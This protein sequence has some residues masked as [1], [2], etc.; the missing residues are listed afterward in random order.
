MAQ[1]R[2]VTMVDDIDGRKADETVSFGLD[3]VLYEID[4]NSKK[5]AALR[6][7]LAE[8]VSAGR[9]IKPPS[10]FRTAVQTRPGRGLAAAGTTAAEVREWAETAGITVSHRGRVSAAL[11]E[12]FLA[13]QDK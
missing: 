11:R 1:Q 5:A 6:K 10:P 4:L 9:Q 2:T 12:Q 8:F 3:G 7:S 13:A